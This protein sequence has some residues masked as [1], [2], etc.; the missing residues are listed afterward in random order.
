V[1]IF[2]LRAPKPKADE[3]KYRSSLNLSF[4]AATAVLPTSVRRRLPRSS[5]GKG[6][7]SW[8]KGSDP[9]KKTDYPAVYRRI[10]D[11]AEK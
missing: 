10:N 9:V 3:G 7:D 1:P 2:L 6:H 11:T 4:V 5:A 8:K